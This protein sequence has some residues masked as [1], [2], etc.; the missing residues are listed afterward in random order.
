[1]P[2]EYQN[3]APL[4]SQPLPVNQGFY[5][6]APAQIVPQMAGM[7]PGMTIPQP[8]MDDYVR[9][10]DEMSGYLTW[11]AM[12]VPPWLNLENVLPPG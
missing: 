6:S 10:A 1:M 4:P 7:M 11:Q 3:F 8:S 5:Q 12:E 9:T 2:P